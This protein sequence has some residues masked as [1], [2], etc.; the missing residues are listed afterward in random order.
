M[1]KYQF[2]SI[3]LFFV[4]VD[5]HVQLFANDFFVDLK[6]FFTRALEVRGGIVG[7]CYP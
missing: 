7:A 4:E 6:D 2:L 3:F 1:R 5:V